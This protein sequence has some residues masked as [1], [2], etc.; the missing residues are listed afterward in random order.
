MGVVRNG[1]AVLA[2]S[3]AVA[4]AGQTGAAAS[5]QYSSDAFGPLCVDSCLSRA[6]GGIVWGART[7]TVSG[8]VSLYNSPGYT[9][10]FVDAF[11]GSTKVASQTRTTSGGKISFKFVMTYARPGGI[12]RIRTQICNTYHGQRVCSGQENDIRN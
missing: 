9:T 6:S 12:N 7:A 4:V 11:A 10:L 8:S 2:A 1:I 3:A 5:V